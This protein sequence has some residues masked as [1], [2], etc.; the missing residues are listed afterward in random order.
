MPQGP[1]ATTVATKTVGNV[2]TGVPLLADAVGLAEFTVGGSSATLAIGA[3]AVVKAGA[4]RLAK[5]VVVT[6]GSASGAFTL[7]DCATTGAASS[8]NLIWSLPYNA[9]T[10]VAG[11]V[12]TLDWPCTTGLVV[13][14]VPGSGTP[15]IN[16][17]YT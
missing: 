17:S 6:P 16:V 11:A 15:V 9:T 14:A 2:T 8:A 4:T 1:I 10:N 5:I 12:F 13:S 7:N 3:A